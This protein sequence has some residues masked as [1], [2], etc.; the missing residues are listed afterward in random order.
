MT[1]VGYEMELFAFVESANGAEVAAIREDIFF[2]IADIAQDEGAAWA[3]PSQLT[4]LSRKPQVD[5]RKETQAAQMVQAWQ[6]GNENPFPD[7]SA[8]RLAQ[9]R[10]T[11]PYPPQQSREAGEPQTEANVQARQAS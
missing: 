2:R 11:I 9:L 8:P 5:A 6:S 7:V 4:F 1:S 3:V 10:G